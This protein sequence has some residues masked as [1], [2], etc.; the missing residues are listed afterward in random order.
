M[1]KL[2]FNRFS[3]C[4]Q[5]QIISSCPRLYH[6]EIFFHIQ[7][8]FHEIPFWSQVCTEM[9][10]IVWQLFIY[11][12]I[13]SLFEINPLLHGAFPL[14]IFSSKSVNEVIGTLKT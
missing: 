3:A 1:R 12:F 9:T 5:L 2:V 10:K 6:K 8:G 13:Y 14:E 11:L 4:F 7:K